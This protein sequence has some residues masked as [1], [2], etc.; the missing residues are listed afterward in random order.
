MVPPYPKSVFI[1]QLIHVWYVSSYVSRG[2]CLEE[3]THL[4][5]C[6][7]TFKSHLEEL[8]QAMFDEIQ[9]HLQAAVE[10]CIAGMR[11]FRVQHDG[12][13]IKEVSTKIPL[14]PRWRNVTNLYMLQVFHVMFC[15]VVYCPLFRLTEGR[16]HTLSKITLFSAHVGSRTSC[17]RFIIIIWIV[18]RHQKGLSPYFLCI[19]HSV[20][21]GCRT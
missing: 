10:N 8:N 5:R 6:S 13:R 19:S 11:Y 21:A 3:D 7:E 16:E 9:N 18:R 15:Y 4:R 12:P 20:A 17:T 1:V 2:D 14:V